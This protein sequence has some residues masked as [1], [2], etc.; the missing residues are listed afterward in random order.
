MCLLQ[1]EERKPPIQLSNL[2]SVVSVEPAE[3]GVWDP[4]QLTHWLRQLGTWFRAGDFTAT[5]FWCALGT[6][7]ATVL[8]S[9]AILQRTFIELLRHYE[10][11]RDS[12][13]EPEAV[14]TAAQQLQEVGFALPRML[15][16]AARGPPRNTSKPKPQWLDFAQSA[17]LAQEEDEA[18]CLEA[19]AEV[20]RPAC[21]PRFYVLFLCE[22]QRQASGFEEALNVFSQQQPFH[23]QCIA[24]DVFRNDTSHEALCQLQDKARESVFLVP[25]SIPSCSWS[26]A[27]ENPLREG[28]R[29]P[30]VGASRAAALRAFPVRVWQSQLPT[31]HHPFPFGLDKGRRSRAGA[32]DEAQK[33]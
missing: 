20:S 5:A 23:L 31:L 29:R 30:L 26:V 1:D 11:V 14:E 18:I 3:T 13:D 19:P 16:E 22:D 10:D 17:T 9:T 28:A 32:P 6:C 21:W 15:S 24:S 2:R 7:P 4:D 33:S 12:W 27:R 25:P 8:S